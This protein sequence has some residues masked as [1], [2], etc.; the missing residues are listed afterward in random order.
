MKCLHKVA[1][2]NG[3]SEPTGLGQIAHPV[4]S[5]SSLRL[6]SSGQA[7]RF[8]GPSQLAA[9]QRCERHVYRQIFAQ[10]FGRAVTAVQHAQF[11]PPQ[12][13]YC[14][15]WRRWNA[16]HDCNSAE[17]CRH[18]TALYCICLPVQAVQYGFSDLPEYTRLVDLQRLERDI[19]VPFCACLSSEAALPAESGGRPHLRY[20]ALKLLMERAAACQTIINEQRCCLAQGS[21]HG[22]WL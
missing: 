11:C 3:K 8:N 10:L 21:T 20:I 16:A 1:P 12:S 9:E 5:H 19:T 13:G 18:G 6:N 15:L 2:A 14:V 4:F 22:P 7:S 17:S